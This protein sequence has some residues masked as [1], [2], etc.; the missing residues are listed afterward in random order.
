MY[1]LVQNKEKVTQDMIPSG[2]DNCNTAPIPE[3]NKHVFAENK[4]RIISNLVPES[5]S[6]DQSVR[7]SM[8]ENR[9]ENISPQAEEDE[10]Q[11]IITTVITVCMW[12]HENCKID[13]HFK[14]KWQEKQ[15][16]LI[17]DPEITSDELSVE[18]PQKQESKNK[19]VKPKTNFNN[20]KRQWEQGTSS[21]DAASNTY[22]KK[23]SIN[24][25]PDNVA[26]SK[27]KTKFNAGGMGVSKTLEMLKVQLNQANKKDGNSEKEQ[28]NYE[29]DKM[30]RLRQAGVTREYL[31]S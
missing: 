16:E 4:S 7:N 28:R 13:S 18:G 2:K 20:V 3:K 9:E 17:K 14:Y 27:N 31:R 6:V 30:K 5:I 15:T 12:G 26:S 21:K 29:L 19:S 10:C 8:D 22:N 25:I 23:S 1:N 24:S 11:L